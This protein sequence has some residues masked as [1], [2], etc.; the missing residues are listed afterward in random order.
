MTPELKASGHTLVEVMLPKDQY[1]I[2]DF[3]VLKAQYDGIMQLMKEK[4]VYS[5]YTV[6]DGGVIEAVYK[7]AFGNAVGVQFNNDLEL[8]SL[9]QKDYGHIILE[10]E[11]DEVVTLP[12]TRIIGHTIKDSVMIYHDETLSLD[13]AYQVYESVL[14]DVY[15]T[16]EKAPTQDIIV[17]DCHQRSEL[18]AKQ[19]I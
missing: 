6:K 8:D 12:H 10:V 1:H 11:N 13:E 4:K 18:K 14:D 9:I 17:K 2:Y 19:N 7:M 16:T 15:P 3:D 5:A